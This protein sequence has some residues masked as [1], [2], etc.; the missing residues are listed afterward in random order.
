MELGLY[1]RHSLSLSKLTLVARDRSRR[2][3]YPRNPAYFFPSL[4]SG[5]ENAGHHIHAVI[6]FSLTF[7]CHNR[8]SLVALEVD[9]RISTQKLLAMASLVPLWTRMARPDH[10][11]T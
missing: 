5:H 8:V 2:N 4:L 11:D 7:P 3:L 6:L 10:M 9:F 1:P